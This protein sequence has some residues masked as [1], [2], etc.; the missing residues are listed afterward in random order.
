M[1]V[2]GSNNQGFDYHVDIVMCIDAT[3][4]M[5]PIIEEV[6]TN[7]LSFYQKVV[8][9]MEGLEKPKNV[10]QLRL[11]VIAFRD[12]GVD[13]EPMVESRFFTLGEDGEN[14]AFRDFVAGIEASGGGD[15]EENALEA[16]AL[17][18]K[19]EWDRTGSVRRHIILMYTDAAAL[20]LGER[21]GSPGYPSGLPASLAELH[22]LWEGQDME[23][24]AK[25]L[26]LFAP[27]C[28]PWTSMVDWTNAMH[29]PCKL[30][31]GGDDTDMKT[32][33]RLLA[34]SI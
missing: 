17:A 15:A 26:M 1:P 25:R 9:E 33:V 16:L 3:G 31:G 28:D 20:K 21:A 11:K 30:D 7:A 27:D 4:S 34:N 10:Q 23:K 13:S 2:G 24:R 22:E 19:S 6:K 32:C 18:M 8:D 12:Y 5:S 14:S 29:F